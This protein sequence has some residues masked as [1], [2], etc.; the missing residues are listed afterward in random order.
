MISSI[1]IIFLLFLISS[2]PIV[3]WAYIFSYGN[4]TSINKKRFIIWILWWA[5]SVFP[6]LYMDKF[7]S[8]IDFKYLDIFYYIHKLSSIYDSLELTFSLF[9]F[10]IFLVLFSFF[11]WTFVHKF[12]S[13][14]KIYLKNILVFI[15]FIILFSSFSYVLDLSFFYFDFLN[16]SIDENISFWNLAFNSFKLIIFYYLLIAFIEE[17]S[18]HFNFLQSSVLSID[19]VKSWVLYSIFVALGFALIE[20]VLYLYNIYQYSWISM[21]LLQTYFFRSIFSVMVHVFCSS[22]VAYYFSKA[23][24]LY[25][26]RDL[27]FPYLKIF[28]T[29][30][31][32]WI[33]LH[34]IFD[35]TITLWFGF[36]IFLYFVFWYLYVSSIFY[37]E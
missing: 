28:I 35:I 13:I 11:L 14:I 34:S 8:I 9:S 3:L 30:L 6:I 31:F 12:H 23:L 20:N 2:F 7:L 32:F 37:K 1:F 25:R 19:S 27:S 17:T 4:D 16:F 24:L 5:L 21:E 18:K 33:L 15:F 26:D 22:L 10:L 29:G 36:I